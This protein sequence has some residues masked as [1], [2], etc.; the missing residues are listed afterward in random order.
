LCIN[1]FS[2]N[3]QRFECPVD[4]RNQK[5]QVRFD[6]TRRERFVVYFN[7]KRMG[8]ALPLNLHQNAKT[9]RKLNGEGE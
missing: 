6:R 9:V 4:L 8:E 7:D 3:N 1:V 5:V 2:I